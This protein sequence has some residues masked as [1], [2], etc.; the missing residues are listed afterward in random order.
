VENPK[1]YSSANIE[2]IDLEKLQAIA[3][4]GAPIIISIF[5]VC[6]VAAYLYLR[7]TKDT[8]ESVSEIKLDVRR[9][10]T[11]LGIK[12]ITEDPN[13][14]IVAGEI[15]QIKSKIFLSRLVDSLNLQVSYF[16]KGNVLNY[17]LYKSSPFIV[18]VLA[19]GQGETEIPIY[20]SHVNTSEF[21]LT[22]DSE[23]QKVVAKFNTPFTIGGTTLI[24]KK[25]DLYEKMDLDATFFVIHSKTQL[26]NT[27]YRS[28]QVDPLN[29][30]A[31]TI[32]ISCKDNNALKAYDI[33]NKIDSLYIHY[34]NE[35]KNLANSQKIDWLNRE[36]KQL[37]GRMEDYENYFENFTIQNKSSDLTS[38]L[39]RIIVSINKIDSQRYNLNKRLIELNSIIDGL[40][41]NLNSKNLLLS[42][43]LLPVYINERLNSLRLVAHQKEQLSMTYNDNTFALRQKEKELNDLR[44]EVFNSLKS[45]RQ[46]WMSAMTELT[47]QKK[48]LEQQFTTLPDKNT[49]FLKNQ[50]FYNLFTEFYLSMM[51]SKSEFEIAMAGSVP[52]FKILSS[53]TLPS[54]PV[55]PK[56]AMIYG[57]GF[58]LG[59]ISALFALGFMYVLNN[60]ITSLKEVEDTVEVPILGVIPSS[61]QP[62]ISPFF[63]L[64]N[65]QAMLSEAIRSL[66]TNLDFF[67]SESGKKVITITSTVSGE[68]K[69][70]IALNLG[71]VLAL[72]NK[73]AVIIDL[74]MR[75]PKKTL[76]SAVQNLNQGLSTVLIK[77]N[78]WQD[79]IQQTEIANLDFIP[80]GPQPPN[81]SELLLNGAFTNLVDELKEKYDFVLMDT[82]PVGLVTDAVL[83]MR[84]SNLS[85]YVVR[86]NYSKND[87]LRNIDRVKTM[88]KLS[89][90]AVVINSLNQHGKTYGYGYYYERPLKKTWS[91]ILKS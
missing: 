24:I 75:K 10:A 16:N 46:S 85:I 9:D 90:M 86:A 28:I 59:L 84:K 74:D 54:A 43:P 77:K 61:R 62:K 17:E 12:T 14:N 57:I 23:P 76:P 35:Q 56:R 25:T 2:G 37:E 73:K 87:F 6:N 32:R 72:S 55:S 68:G 41:L 52:D 60:K 29:L 19:R 71:A 88:N 15:E 34:S 47:E 7:Y 48:K 64:D 70:F 69:S 40:T 13:A 53:A 65:P 38:D 80:S 51:Q 36:L 22:K 81:P 45:V 20:F 42:Y 58:S 21:Q 33:V 66:R 11:E 1:N 50:R 78:T 82:P 79:C 91:D 63:V 31:N 8:F 39:K 26:V 4:K 89:N 44:D 3:K 27:L 83:A 30:N 18:E 49:Q 67:T 5:L